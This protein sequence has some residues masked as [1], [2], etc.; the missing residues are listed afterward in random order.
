MHHHEDVFKRDLESHRIIQD[1]DQCNKC[2]LK[3]SN[4]VRRRQRPV[5][6]KNYGSISKIMGNN[7]V[8]EDQDKL[9][10]VHRQLSP[11]KSTFISPADHVQSSIS[12]WN[13]VNFRSRTTRYYCR[14][15]KIKTMKGRQMEYIRQTTKLTID[16]RKA[17]AWFVRWRNRKV[18]PLT[19]EQFR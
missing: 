9:L 19:D 7:R 2:L 14:K 16:H 11:D 18:R 5:I 10:L 17:V 6:I 4:A 15:F 12:F 8:E 13:K 1:D 3:R